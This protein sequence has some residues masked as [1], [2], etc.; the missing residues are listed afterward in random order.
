MGH[1]RRGRA[2]SSTGYAIARL[3]GPV[4]LKQGSIKVAGIKYSAS[5]GSLFTYAAMT[6]PP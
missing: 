6:L 5:P 1:Y 4:S 2:F 3:R